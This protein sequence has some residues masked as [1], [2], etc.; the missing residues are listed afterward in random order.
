MLRV[1]KKEC[2]S[3][4][5]AAI[6]SFFA[7]QTGLFFFLFMI[8][9]QLLVFKSGIRVA[10][11]AMLGVGVSLVYLGIKN[12]AGV[13]DP[14]IK[15]I[16]LLLEFAVPCLLMGGFLMMNNTAGRNPNVLRN[17]F[18]ATVL[19]AGFSV[20][21]FSLARNGVIEEHFRA[22]FASMLN[23]LKSSMENTGSYELVPLMNMDADSML[24]MVSTVFYRGYLF[25]YFCILFLTYT[26]AMSIDKLTKH[27]CSIITVEVPDLFVWVLVAALGTVLLDSRFPLGA[28]G[29]L[30][31]N[32]FLIIMFLYGLRGL[33]IIRQIFEAR[34]V[35]AFLRFIITL[36]FVSMLMSPGIGRL[37]LIAIPCIGIAEVWFKYKRT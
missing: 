31:W 18:V 6:V 4:L 23:T 35:P 25:A 21:I 7:Y 20:L 29:Y 34:K 12:T 3:A 5:L 28:A 11:I 30:G 1:D 19:T 24:E 17:I 27:Q 32:V 15:K 8:P 22:N 26:F 2:I 16:L 14:E 37:L 13:T 36:I 33:S 9:L 10:K